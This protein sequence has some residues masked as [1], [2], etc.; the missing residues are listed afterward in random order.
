MTF[1]DRC[2]NAPED[3]LSKRPVKD[4]GIFYMHLLMKKVIMLLPD[5]YFH[6]VR[7]VIT[8]KANTEWVTDK[9]LSQDS[10]FLFQTWLH[11][12]YVNYTWLAW[13]VEPLKKDIHGQA[14]TQIS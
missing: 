12:S 4:L 7:I 2:L 10:H 14:Q 1:D 13:P 6:Q 3:L 9:K 5:T 11:I 8:F